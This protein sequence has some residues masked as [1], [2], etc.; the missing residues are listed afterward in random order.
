[1]FGWSENNNGVGN[2]GVVDSECAKQEDKN[3]I[4]C[5]LICSMSST[6]NE[7]T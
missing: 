7:F 5:V 2:N 4:M 3:D 6:R 1:M